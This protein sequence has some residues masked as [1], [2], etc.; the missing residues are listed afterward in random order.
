MLALHI[1]LQLENDFKTS[2][3]EVYPDDSRHQ[4]AILLFQNILCWS[5]S[6]GVEIPV[7]I[8]RLFQNILCWSLSSSVSG[9]VIYT[10]ISKHL[11]LKFIGN[12][13]KFRLP[14]G[15]FK[16]SYVEVYLAP[17]KHD[18]INPPIFQNILCWSLSPDLLFRFNWYL[19]FKTSYVE[20]YRLR[21]LWKSW[22]RRISKH[23]MLKF[24]QTLQ[25]VCLAHCTFQNILCWSLSEGEIR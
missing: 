15:N 22:Q 20:V 13:F 3:V 5:L 9:L 2:Y 16:T 18:V 14:E 6:G 10:Y 23:L 12:T 17:A 21:Q 11:M 24:I 7:K 4:D 1:L 25:T 19:H 8:T